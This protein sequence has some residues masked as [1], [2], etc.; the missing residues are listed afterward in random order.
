M[1][2]LHM[3]ALLAAGFCDLP[4][5]L[6]SL[7]RRLAK[8]DDLLDACVLCWQAERLARGTAKR[9]PLRPERDARGLRMEIWY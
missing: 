3:K 8:P 5:W 7:D 1:T 2:L 9:L 6:K 4:R